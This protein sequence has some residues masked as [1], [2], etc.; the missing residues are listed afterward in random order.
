MVHFP[1]KEEHPEDAHEEE[2][3]NRNQMA[4]IANGL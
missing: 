2:E 3:N 4:R 1:V